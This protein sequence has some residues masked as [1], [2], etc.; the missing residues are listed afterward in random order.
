MSVIN[1]VYSN[2]PENSIDS[3]KRIIE[4]AS[5][6][7]TYVNISNDLAD[8]LRSKDSKMALY[9]ANNALMIAKKI[10]FKSGMAKSLRYIA[11]INSRK[12]NYDSAIEYYLESKKVY[13]EIGDKIGIAHISTGTGILYWR[14]KRY[15]KALEY[16]NEALNVYEELGDKENIS[17]ALGNLGMVSCNLKKYNKAIEYYKEAIKITEEL[18]NI[19]NLGS[20]L[21]NIGSVYTEMGNYEKALEYY[22]KALEITKQI[23]DELGCAVH[24]INI[25]ELYYKQEK[26]NKTIGLLNKSLNLFKKYEYVDGIL[27][28]YEYIHKTYEK[29]NNTEKAYENYKHYV[30]LKDSIFSKETQQKIASLEFQQERIL[31]DKQ[32]EIQKLELEQKKLIIYFSIAGLIL[33]AILTFFIYNRY[34]LNKNAKILLEAKNWLEIENRKKVINL[35]GQQVSQ[36]IVDELLNDTSAEATKKKFVCIMFLDI[37]G[38][39]PLMENKE[40]EEI[41]EYQN[42]V[43][44]FMIEIINKHHGI[45]NQF[46][47]DGYMATFGAPVSK[48]N[49]CQNAVDAAIEIVKK[50]NEKSESGV[51]PHTRIGIGL[52][53]GDVVAGNVG[54]SVRKQY[55]IT[56]NTVILASRIEQLNKKYNSQI[57]I[58]EDVFKNVQTGNLKYEDIGSVTIKGREESMNIIKLF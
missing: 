52:H 32:I 3:L 47:G 11:T 34:R 42:A 25:G 54:T 9:Y 51:I 13:K 8:K 7:T 29:L 44:G 22:K 15:Q 55:S 56:G 49:D 37:R 41:I 20:H 18:K 21:G 16:W 39:T 4:S 45:I 57:L 26:Y 12:G 27:A 46:L 2:S 43:F 53:A 24:F 33:I 14:L 28:A 31:K 38:F 40:P 10:N 6:D 35:F 50:V 19:E 23:G 17:I 1:I 58:S 36:E 48:G 30:T 5:H